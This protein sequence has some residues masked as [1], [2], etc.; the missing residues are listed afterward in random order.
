[1]NN[2]RRMEGSRELIRSKSAINIEFDLAGDLYQDLLH[3]DVVCHGVKRSAIQF[4]EVF[5]HLLLTS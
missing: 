4:N 3:S 1:M 5:L 2:K